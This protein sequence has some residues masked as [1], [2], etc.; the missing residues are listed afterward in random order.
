MIEPFGER[1]A[2]VRAAA[3]MQ[4]MANINRSPKRK[5]FSLSD[6]MLEVDD[7]VSQLVTEQKPQTWQEQKDII[8]K[9]FAPF[10][11]QQQAKQKR[12]DAAA[13]RRAER[14]KK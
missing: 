5:P 3:Q 9:M 1:W 10:A 13:K 11:A 7:K 4:L 2:D 14:A 6:F 8:K 12:A